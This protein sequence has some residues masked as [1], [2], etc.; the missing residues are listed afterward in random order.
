MTT[1][2]NPGQTA[3]HPIMRRLLTYTLIALQ[4]L[5][6]PAWAAAA[7]VV[8]PAA[9]VK[10]VLN[11][12]GNGVPI[13]QIV[14]PNGAG[15]SH[16]KFIH[17][18]VGAEGQILNNSGQASFSQLAGSVG[19]NP[20][21]GNSNARLILNEVTSAH[22]STLNGL[23]EITG[24]RADLVIANPNGISVDGGGFLNASRATLTTGKPQ[25]GG[26][27]GLGGLDIRQGVIGVQGKG[28]DARGA[29]Q[30]QLLS[31]SLILN[32]HLHGNNVEAVAGAN[33]IDLSTGAITQQTGSGAAPQVAIDIGRLGGMYAGSIYLI[34]TEAGVGVN[35]KGKLHALVGDI[36][37]SSAGDL[38]MD[39]GEAKARW[40]I[41]ADAA[42]DL[43]LQ[44]A[45][46]QAGG[47]LEL[48][49]GRH[50]GVAAKRVDTA[51]TTA[52]GNTTTTTATAQH[53]GTVL[54]AGGDIGLYAGQTT[55]GG[56]LGLFGSALRA[57]GNATLSGADITVE[58]LADSKLVRSVTVSSSRKC[59][60]WGKCTTTTTTDTRQ[61]LDETLKVGDISAAGDIS[62]LALGSRDGDGNVLAGTG[63][64]LLLGAAVKSDLGQIAL[65]AA[66]DLEIEASQTRHSNLS[67][68]Q[69]SSKSRWGWG[70]DLIPLSSANSVAI[71]AGVS[72]LAEGS[73]VT[74]DS[75][76]LRAGRD[77]MVRGSVLSADNDIRL[78]SGGDIDILE[79]RDLVSRQMIRESKQK[80]LFSSGLFG[81]TLGTKNTSQRLEETL[82]TAAAAQIASINGNVSLQSGRDLRIQGADI[83]AGGDL[84]LIGDNVG[85]YAADNIYERK[86]THKTRTSGLTLALKGGA[87][88]YIEAAWQATRKAT[89]SDDDRLQAAYAGKAG[90]NLYQALAADNNLAKL[91]GQLGDLNK[92]FDALLDGKNTGTSGVNLELTLGSNGSES[93]SRQHQVT[94]RAADLAST[95]DTTVIARAGVAGKGNIDIMGSQL[96]AHDLTLSA[97]NRLTARYAPQTSVSQEKSSNTAASVGIGLGSDGLY[98]TVSGQVGNARGEALK[99]DNGEARL[100]AGNKLTLL[101][102]GDTTFKGA[103]AN[104]RRIEA[105]IG[106]DLTLQ[107]LQDSERYRYKSS[108]AG[109]SLQIGY[110]KVGGSINAGK[111][112]ISNQFQSVVEQSGLYA[113]DGGFDLRVGKATRLDGAVIASG[114]A[115]ALN[116]LSTE[117]LAYSDLANFEQ[118]RVSGYSFGLGTGA[119]SNYVMPVAG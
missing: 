28:L 12:G 52:A 11:A 59:K 66:R 58:S 27:G 19:G 99:E 97:G 61:T 107:S 98:F 65:G 119:G 87:L 41:R 14:P 13:V 20:M 72:L 29:E 93:A 55:Q 2:E 56:K 85:I 113:G 33:R 91:G 84:D 31:R 109:G 38:N 23:I 69:S 105:D 90:Y 6:P 103:L 86:E 3:P 21:L 24:R 67:D 50:L 70:L 16:N 78:A 94:Y 111:L 8:D 1:P 40:D 30:L 34:G 116:R 37:L 46:I 49:A 79:A 4:G 7:L 44:A 62:L 76:S 83:L 108:N 117:S 104:A 5:S 9:A 64:L 96:A 92:S 71:D 106:G 77:L 51:N 17:Y 48:A 47:D 54:E 80:G 110:G 74:G 10:P 89:H 81:I 63:N 25:F 68:V 60:W 57:A 45:D 18:N 43:S 35:S 73:L 39:G 75:L 101:S 53:T 100:K 26:D 22:P 115:A 102:G 32:A 95:G 114:A 118:T 36:T 82:D 15:V 88:D 112:D 42:R